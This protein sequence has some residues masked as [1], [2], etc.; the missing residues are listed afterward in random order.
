MT[1]SEAI[2]EAKRRLAG[3][4]KS[5]TEIQWIIRDT[6]SALKGWNQTDIITKGD[7]EITDWLADKISSVVV[8]LTAGEPI[9]YI[10]GQARFMGMNFG[11]TPAVLIPRPETEQLVDMAVDAAADRTD[12][13]IKDIGTG[14]GCIAISLA[15]A[16][17][18]PSVE[19]TD[20]SDAALAVAKANAASLNVK[21]DFRNENILL[22]K[23]PADAYDIIV[24]NPPYIAQSE[25]AAMDAVV[26]EHEPALALFVPDSEPLKFY[27]SIASYAATALSKGGDLWLEINPRF[28]E[29]TRAA[30][31][32]AGFMTVILIRDERGKQRFIHAR[33]EA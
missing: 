4:G 11:V 27:N 28:A 14:S 2:L 1:L 24:S 29:E 10:L 17:K 15:R 13:R 22:S 31:A 32:A 6:L 18:F 30:V 7:T 5:A 16:L 19:A 33:R 12:L 21:V 9:Q 23:A 26:K 20:V 3:A 25:E 8:R